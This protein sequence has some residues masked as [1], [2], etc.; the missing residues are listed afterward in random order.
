[1][2]RPLR[3]R[4]L[5]ADLPVLADFW[6]EWCAP[7]RMIAPVVEDLAREYEG[8]LKVAKVDVDENKQLAMRYGIMS[9]PTLGLFR[10]G[11]LVERIVG[12]MPKAELRRQIDAVLR[13]DSQD[14]V[15]A[16]N[17]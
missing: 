2:S 7:C 1:M 14:V 5:K 15:E 4:S 3:R 17:G 6:A 11:K 9:I 8:R 13:A 10:D 12:Y 16:R